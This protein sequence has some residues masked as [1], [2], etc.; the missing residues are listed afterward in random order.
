MDGTFAPHARHPQPPPPR[1]GNGLAITA[2]VFAALFFIPLMPT[3]GLILGVIALLS[4]RSKT[5]SIVAV[6]I[7]GFL[8]IMTILYVAIAIPAFMT[9][10]KHAKSIEAKV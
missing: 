5:I 4:G 6:S 7:G 2:L 10:I 3:I 9:Y 8:T 1:K